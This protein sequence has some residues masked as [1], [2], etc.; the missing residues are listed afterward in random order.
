MK[1]KVS[2]GERIFN[3]I[4]IVF[5]ICMMVIMAYPLWHV[6]CSSFSNNNELMAHSGILLYPLKM[7]IESYKAVFANPVIM[8]GY[9]NT[10]FILVGGL[11]INMS[12]TTLAAYVLSRKNA[13]LTGAFMKMIIFTMYFSGGLIPH[14]LLISRTLGLNNSLWAVILPIAINTYNLI[15]MRTSFMEIPDSLCESAMLDGA[16]HWTIF[17][18]IILPLS[19]AILAVITLYYAVSHWNSW[20][21]ASIYLK[22]RELY[23]LQLVLREILIQNDTES[24]ILGVEMGD[25]YSVAETIKYAV[26][27]VATVPILILYPFLQKYFVKGTMAGAVKG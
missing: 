14:Y 8:K 24:M 21:T 16:G 9:I 18:K 19:K 27:V 2:L 23:P 13:M 25:R 4:N 7:N 3:I 22:D 20:F 10:L 5:M 17:L 26:I 11:A 15:I 6:L 12:M 1:I